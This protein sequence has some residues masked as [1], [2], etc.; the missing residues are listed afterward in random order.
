MY[1]RAQIKLRNGKTGYK[2]YIFETGALDGF[3]YLE[4]TSGEVQAV[5][6]R[7]LKSWEQFNDSLRAEE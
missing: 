7:P 4:Q 1:V 6:F 5:I 3:E 2:D